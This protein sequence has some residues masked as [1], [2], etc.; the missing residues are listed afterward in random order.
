M[1]NTLY[2]GRPNYT[3]P[4]QGMLA[5]PYYNELCEYSWNFEHRV[6]TIKSSARKDE[7]ANRLHCLVYLPDA[8]LPVAILDAQ[9]VRTETGR[10][11]GKA[12]VDFTE[13]VNKHSP[14]ILALITKL[15]PDHTWNGTELVFPEFDE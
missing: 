1:T 5:F 15:V 8:Q 6:R 12:R 13:A 2:P 4:N 11:F 3:G 7:I 9:N 14:K 10:A